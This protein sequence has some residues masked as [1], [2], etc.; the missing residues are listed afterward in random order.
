M[1]GR[2]G[3]KS[4]A[5]VDRFIAEMSGD[6]RRAGYVL[7]GS[8]AFLYEMCRKSVLRALVPEEMRDFCLHDLDLGQ[9]SIFEALDLAQTPSLMTPFQVLFLRNVKTL[10]GRGQKKEEF[11]AIDAYFRRPNPQ[12]L[13]IFVADHVA[14]PQ[15][16]RKMDMTEKERAEKIRETL[17]DVCGVV[18]LQQVSE[19]DAV[20]WVM[21]EAEAK[22]VSFSEDAARELVDALSAEMLLVAS[23][24][25]K[26]LLYAGA[27]GKLTVEVGDV[28]TMVSAAKQRSLYELTDAISLKDA[29][30]ALV[31]LAGLLNAS[32][33]GEDA[34]IGH[35]FSLAKTFRQ[36]LVLNEKK[37]RDQRAMWQVLWPGFRVAPFAADALIA[38]ARRYKDRG[39]LT[40]GLRMIAKADMEL[41]SSPADKR[42]VLERLV[43]RL[44]GKARGEDMESVGG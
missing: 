37:V 35:V 28:E 33:G 43:M 38:Q 30:R 18:E 39:E 6:A 41:R 5:G 31:L 25:E 27:L 26:L 29:P 17:G 20:R 34:A 4:F 36:M 2:D 13:V 23:E 40:R 10:Y 19:E 24:L 1:S 21:R 15:D 3:L 16:L 32:E 22:G 44:A 14:L 12:A 11:K 8:E 7:L 9:T 42:L